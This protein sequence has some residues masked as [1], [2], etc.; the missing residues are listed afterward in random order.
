MEKAGKHIFQRVPGVT[1]L[2]QR[3]PG[4]VV[5]EKIKEQNGYFSPFC[6][7]NQYKICALSGRVSTEVCSPFTEKQSSL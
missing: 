1:F 5:N 6:K 3:V 7:N 2:F 4:V